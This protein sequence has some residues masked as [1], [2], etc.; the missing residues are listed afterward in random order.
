MRGKDGRFLE[1]ALGLGD[2]LGDVVGLE[3]RHQAVAIG[4]DSVLRDEEAVG[5]F[6]CGHALADALEYLKLALAELEGRG[7]LRLVIVAGQ[8]LELLDEGIVVV[9]AA[10]TDSFDGFDEGADGTVLRHDTLYVEAC[11]SCQ[12]PGFLVHGVDEERGFRAALADG[13]Q[14]FE[15]V[16]VGQFEVEYEEVEVLSF[17][18]EADE[19]AAL[20]HALHLGIGN[21]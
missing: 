10:F 17:G 6:W 8:Q 19:L 9:G 13:L 3:L 16:D 12:Y 20:G 4:A 7:A 2:K 5:D 14:Y 1:E 21:G 18:D 11:Q 15:A